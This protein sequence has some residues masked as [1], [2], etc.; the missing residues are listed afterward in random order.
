M[1]TKASI[2][3]IR[4]NGTTWNERALKHL[5]KEIIIDTETGE[6]VQVFKRKIAPH[7]LAELMAISPQKASSI[8]QEFKEKPR[9]ER[10][11]ERG[12]RCHFKL[13]G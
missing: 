10:V 2:K 11:P 5:V 9:Y 4:L 6:E 12:G 13:V 7:E 8:L 1:A 3:Q